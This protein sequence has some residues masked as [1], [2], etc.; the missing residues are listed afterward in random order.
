[1]TTLPFNLRFTFFNN[2]WLAQVKKVQTNPPT[3]AAQKT[4]NLYVPRTKY[5][6]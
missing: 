4:D 6:G 3:K 5:M 1:M 2:G